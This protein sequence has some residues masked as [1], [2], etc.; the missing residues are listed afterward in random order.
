MTKQATSKSIQANP[1]QANILATLISLFNINYINLYS[2][3]WDT[4]DMD[5]YIHEHGTSANTIPE[6]VAEQIQNLARV[7]FAGAFNKHL[8]DVN[9]KQDHEEWYGLL[10]VNPSDEEGNSGHH[11]FISVHY[12]TQE[13]NDSGATLTISPEEKSFRLIQEREIKSFSFDY[14]GSGDSGGMDSFEALGKDGNACDQQV[15]R[16]L[17]ELIE[18]QIYNAAGADFNNDGSQGRGNCDCTL[19]NDEG[20]L[21]IDIA[22]EDNFNET[23]YFD[24]EYPL[25]QQAA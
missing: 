13:R 2:P 5:I 22:H 7:F 12:S 6:E 21:E 9:D 19:L 1:E 24:D 8:E 17:Q 4:S 20:E 15:I 3:N 16:E 18:E 11:L 25:M 23:H 10:R 14:S